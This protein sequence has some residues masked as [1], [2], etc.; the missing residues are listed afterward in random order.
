[1]TRNCAVIVHWGSEEPTIRAVLAA[2]DTGLFSDVVVVANDRKP[3]PLL[4]N[5]VAI[6]WEVPSRNL[7]FGGACQFG[8][9]SCT[10]KRYAFFN[11]DVIISAT[12]IAKCLEALDEPGIGIAAP[13]LR[14]PDGT[15]QSACGTLSRVI[16]SPDPLNLPLCVQSEPLQ[17][18]W[19]TGAALF[20][21][22]DVLQQVGWDGS[23]FLLCE[24]VDLCLRAGMAGWQVVIVP[25]ATGLHQAGGTLVGIAMSYYGPRNRIWLARRYGSVSRSLLVTLVM[26]LV[27]LRLVLADIVKWRRSHAML[28]ARGIIAGWASL[29]TDKQPQV[30]EP[31]PA[32]WMDSWP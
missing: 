12:D 28:H 6:R 2:L 4:L 20:C 16:W 18:A 27:T 15:L 22:A 17:C 32:R 13:V 26:A 3:R 25:G 14:Y 24:D 30:G 9:D 11:A 31:I 5:K 29:P 21:R 7:G 19:V 23:Y 8:A 1:L 10:A